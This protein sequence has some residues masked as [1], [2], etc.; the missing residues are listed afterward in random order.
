MADGQ[1]EGE[2]KDQLDTLEAQLQEID[3]ILAVSGGAEPELE[4]VSRDAQRCSA[5]ATGSPASH[6][7]T[8]SLWPD[9]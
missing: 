9:R 6:A 4:E 5:T 8:H 3:A 7:L 1:A 2:L